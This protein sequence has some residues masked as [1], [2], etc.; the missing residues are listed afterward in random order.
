MAQR[1]EHAS[2]LPILS[3]AQSDGKRRASAAR[4][5]E[6][7]GFETERFA[8][9]F[10]AAQGARERPAVRDAAHDD[11]VLLARAVARVRDGVKPAAV[12]AEEEHPLGLDVEATRVGERVKIGGQQI[13]HGASRVRIVPR[14]GVSRGFVHEGITSFRVGD[15]AAVTL[16]AVGGGM[17]ARREVADDGAVE[18]HASFGDEAFDAPARAESR[19]GEEGVDARVCA[20]F[21]WGNRGY[22]LA[23]VMLTHVVMIWF[24]KDA[25][26]EAVAQFRARAD[27]ELRGIPGVKH[28]H[29]G[30]P[31]PSD[32]PVVDKSYSVALAMTFDGRA[33][34]GAYAAHPVHQKFSEECIR[35]Y[36]E[37]LLVYDFE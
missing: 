20:C 3:F 16:H 35:P 18:R 10:H 25:P 2:D 32:R 33:E 29:C 6:R 31:I 22:A 36:A 4:G 37:R 14:A 17:D 28:L 9:G 15:G 19:G 11:F 27:A 1:A 24:R 12:V 21:L 8:A 13:V 30:T 34:L 7:R 5:E 23:L 26:A